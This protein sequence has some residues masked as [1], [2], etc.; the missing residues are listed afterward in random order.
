MSTRRS[1]IKKIGGLTV[2]G[3]ISGLAGCTSQSGSGGTNQS[4]SGGQGEPIV[5]GGSVSLSG[6]LSREGQYTRNGYR[7]WRD[8][9]NKK[10]GGIRVGNN[11][12]RPVKLKLYDD[13]TDTETAVKLYQKLVTQ[14]D[15]DLL[16]GPYSS[17]LT[18]A[19]APIAE[20]YQIP[21]VEA[22]GASDKIFNQGYKYIYGVLSPASKYHAGP[23]KFAT[24]LKNPNVTKAGIVHVD[25]LFTNTIADGAS[26]KLKE[27]GIEE[28]FNVSYPEG[29]NDLSNI[30]NTVKN[31]DIDLLL[32]AGHLPDEIL[33]AKQASARNV[34]VPLVVFSGSPLSSDFQTNLGK[35]ARGTATTAQW[36]PEMDLKG[37]IFGTAQNW[38]KQWKQK[39]NAE[40]YYVPAESSAGGVAFQLAIENTGSAKPE[41]VKKALDDLNEMSFFG[42]LKFADGKM[43]GANLAKPM[44]TA[45]LQKNL[46]ATVVA[47]DQYAQGKINYPAGTW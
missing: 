2:A 30:V 28:V 47:P 23:V 37:P 5:F 32:D 41:Q 8:Y 38:S 45:Q 39:Y 40:P 10:Y 33:F 29:T 12:V 26:K 14:D 11:N 1:L 16:L 3:G 9:V 7:L 18:L 27:V 34:E 19:V 43:H 21:M 46:E 24:S 15:V 22:N 25:T 35:T 44:A 17:G 31:S 13:K 42:R 4:G 36:L 6:S 20:K